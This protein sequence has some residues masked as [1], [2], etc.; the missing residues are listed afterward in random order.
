MPIVEDN[1]PEMSQILKN[2]YIIMV[3][4][5]KA[6]KLWNSFWGK[7]TTRTCDC[8]NRLI[9]KAAYGQP[10]SEFG[11]DVHH[12]RPKNQGGTDAFENL[13][14]VHYDTHDEIYGR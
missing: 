1:H 14:I 4:H 5:D 13:R 11:W 8:R 6:I 10:G 7:S 9:Y 2:S 3:D 12:I